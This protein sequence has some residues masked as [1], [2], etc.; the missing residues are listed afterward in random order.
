ANATPGASK[1]QINSASVND[2]AYMAFNHSGSFA[3]LFGIDTDNTW[4]VGGWSMGNVSY[5]ILH[6]G[7]SF[8]RS[9]ENLNFGSRELFSPGKISVSGTGI[10]LY[11]GL[12]LTLQ[13]GATITNYGQTN[14]TNVS[15]A[16]V[17]CQAIN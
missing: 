17:S 6:E 3:A 12:T 13:A 1:L 11:S 7:N 9:G 4:R 5:Q 2:A 15:A 14:V 10:V 16:T 8:A